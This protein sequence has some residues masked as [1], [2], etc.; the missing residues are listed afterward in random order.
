MTGKPA[1]EKWFGQRWWSLFE[2]WRWYTSFL[3]WW[4]EGASDDGHYQPNENKVEF[5]GYPD[6]ESSPYTLPYS[7]DTLCYMGQGNHGLFSHN[8]LNGNQT[9]AYDF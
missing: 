4:M 1:R 5:I 9:Y 7:S 8:K 3:Y 2:H 6:F